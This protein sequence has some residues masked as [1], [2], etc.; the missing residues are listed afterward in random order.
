[1]SPNC[2]GYQDVRSHMMNSR[3]EETVMA[4]VWDVELLEKMRNVGDDWADQVVSDLVKEGGDDEAIKLLRMVVSIHATVPDGMPGE[5]VDY[6]TCN[7]P[8]DWVDMERVKNGE[9][10]YCE[11]GPEIGAF[12]L[13]ASLPACFA[14]A[15]GVNVL[16]ISNQISRYPS[17][18]IIETS[19][20]VIDVMQPGGLSGDGHG[21]LTARKVRLV[22]AVNRHLQLHH[23][24]AQYNLEWGVP[25]NQEDLAMTLMTFAT[26]IL[27][28]MEKLGI[29]PTPQEA[30]D[31]FHAWRYVGFEMGIVEELLPE[32]VAEGRAMMAAISKHQYAASE[33]GKTVNQSLVD[34]LEGMIPGRQLKGLIPTKMRFLVGDDVGDMLG[35]AKSN[36][37]VS[38]ILLEK[39]LLTL[40]HR[41]ASNSRVVRSMRRKFGALLFEGLEQLMREDGRPEFHVPGE[42]REA[43]NMCAAPAVKPGATVAATAV[44]TAETP[45]THA[46]VS[47]PVAAANVAATE[48]D[49]VKETPAS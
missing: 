44:V 6:L 20:F 31:Y 41:Y 18:R 17:R 2:A 4:K 1:L 8:P 26:T 30:E 13:L 47:V 42:L 37:T 12:L 22:H 43:W 10:Y 21:V 33:S 38:L 11:H 23:P 25:L 35:V 39:A 34:F 28:S 49:K 24:E 5:L 48:D 19:R 45:P 14:A 15:K 3:N 29:K 40:G 7:T 16:R 27:D 36:W 46:V 32:N 9:D